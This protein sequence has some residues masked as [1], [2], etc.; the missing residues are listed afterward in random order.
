MDNRELTNRVYDLIRLLPDSMTINAIRKQLGL[1]EADSPAL[2]AVLKTLTDE[3]KIDVT[4]KRQ[5]N[6]R[7]VTPRGDLVYGRVT[8][9]KD[10]CALIELQH[11]PEMVATLSKGQTNKHQPRVGEEFVLALQRDKEGNPRARILAKREHDR[12]YTLC[13]RF[14]RNTGHMQPVTPLK[15][16]FRIAGGSTASDLVGNK[17]YLL[18]IPPDYT[19]DDP[20]VRIRDQLNEPDTG[21]PVSAILAEKYALNTDHPE[22]N[23]SLAQSICNKPLSMNRRRDL[24][25]EPIL[26]IDPVYA[27]DHDDGIMIERTN[28]G[29]RTLVVISDVPYYVPPGSLLDEH[30][31]NNGVT[32]YFSDKTYHMYPPDL[33][34][35]CSLLEGQP[36]PV[37]YVEQFCNHDGE[38]IDEKIGA[39]C[40]RQ[41]RQFTYGKFEDLKHAPEYRAY[42]D[43]GDILIDEARQNR[44]VMSSDNNKTVDQSS[45]SNLL[46]EMMMVRANG[47]VAAF[48]SEK[49]VPAIYR[50][51]KL[52]LNDSTYQDL[53]RKLGSEY[54]MPEDVHDLDHLSLNMI[55]LKAEILGE[56]IRV[57][58]LIRRCLGRAQY[59]Q[60]PDMHYG[61]NLEVYGHCT[62]PIRRIGD[63]HTIR[64]LHTAL[65]NHEYGLDPRHDIDPRDMARHLNQRELVARSIHRDANRF[66]AVRGSTHLQGQTVRGFV[67]AVG[68]DALGIHIHHRGLSKLYYTDALPAGWSLLNGTP[69]YKGRPVEDPNIMIHIGT[70]HPSKGDFDI[71]DVVPKTR[72]SARFRPSE[73]TTAPVMRVA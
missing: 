67:E 61:L 49:D 5:K 29:Y 34:R 43:F 32:H 42:A 45:F 10:K 52:H 73:N 27:R 58:E 44:I 11:R 17:T 30:A 65:G 9:Y 51:H 60:L 12:P 4:T 1:S 71:L 8:G 72:V 46:V 55:L 31:Y 23:I 35:Q 48:L 38:V 47:A 7:A 59:E 68:N 19:P 16:P 20:S 64:C 37:V 14:N 62:S 69:Y 70:M 26:V 15:G 39:G 25:R 18:E 13:G 54:H 36:R 22:E 66:Y 21:R 6:Y 53:R 2:T 33:V 63:T 57:A 40:I 56:Q 50:T 41:Q 24:T 3:G 28:Y